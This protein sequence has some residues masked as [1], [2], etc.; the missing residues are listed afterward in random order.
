M[1]IE[2]GYLAAEV[3]ERTENMDGLCADLRS[4]GGLGR[5]DRIQRSRPKFL[6]FIVTS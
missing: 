2:L 5:A 3:A 1:G 6:D 4:V